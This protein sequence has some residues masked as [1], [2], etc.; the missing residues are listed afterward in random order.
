[1]G[2][3]S[4]NIDKLNAMYTEKVAE[5]S[6]CRQ[7]KQNGRRYTVV[8]TSDEYKSCPPI[9]LSEPA[10]R[11]CI[12]ISYSKDAG[13]LTVEMENNEDLCSESVV[14]HGWKV[15]WLPLG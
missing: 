15:N 6:Q 13:N 4:T 11:S 7:Q 9:V 5:L 14:N 2:A 8:S 10:Y 3:Q 12:L 1:M